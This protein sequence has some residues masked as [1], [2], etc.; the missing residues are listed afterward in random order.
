MKDL[1]YEI[2]IK[3]YQFE[4]L[5]ADDQELV[6]KAR[7]ATNRSY[8]PYSNFH[9]GAALRM[10]NDKVIVGCNQENAVTPVG[11]CAERTAIFSS[12][13]QY[14]GV[15]ILALA[16]SARDVNGNMVET[17][18]SP[19][20]SCRQVIMEQE[21]RYNQPIRILMVGEKGIIVTDTVRNLLPLCFTSESLG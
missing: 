8:A 19:C 21:T 12:Q 4:E 11:L 1:T 2:N 13:A 20:G 16:I 6:I 17:P 7:E 15:P 5:S 3:L 10:K 9:V 18:I 14:P